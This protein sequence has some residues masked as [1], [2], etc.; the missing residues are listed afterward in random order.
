VNSPVKLARHRAEA[1]K[2]GVPI[3]HEDLGPHGGWAGGDAGGVAESG[4]GEG[5][6]IGL[7]RTNEEGG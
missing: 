2:D 5:E 6:S 7:D 3:F 4:S 1:L